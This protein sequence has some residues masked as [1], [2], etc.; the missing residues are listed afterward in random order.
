[1]AK[2]TYDPIKRRAYDR[3]RNLASYGINE[4]KFKQM[5]ER[6][7]G[8]CDICTK[9]LTMNDVVVDHDHRKPKRVRGL[10]HRFCNKLVGNNRNTPAMFRNAARYLESSFDGRQL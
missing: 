10:L 2:R 4:D 5:W 6:Q 9:P 1:V 7:H 3:A 8:L